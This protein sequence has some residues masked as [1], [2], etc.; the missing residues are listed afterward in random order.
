M[1]APCFY[2]LLFRRDG[3][4]F[5]AFDVLAIDGEDISATAPCS[6]ASAGLRAIM[7]PDG[8][9]L[10]YLDHV[11][12]RGVDLFAV[13]CASDLEGIVAK[14]QAHMNLN[15]TG[16]RFSDRLLLDTTS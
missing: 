14:R 7:P 8:L 9:R 5:I 13:V 15:K 10:V 4:H 3:P 12:G 2:R 6:S 16:V 1:A 11:V